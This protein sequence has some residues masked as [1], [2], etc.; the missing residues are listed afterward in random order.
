MEVLLWALWIVSGGFFAAGGHTEEPAIQSYF[1][2][3]DECQRVASHVKKLSG[4]EGQC[5]QAKYFIPTK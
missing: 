2:S 3:V 4:R 5:I 1:V